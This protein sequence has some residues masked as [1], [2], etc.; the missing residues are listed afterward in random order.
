RTEPFHRGG[1]GSRGVVVDDEDARHDPLDG[2]RQL[3]GLRDEHGDERR[4]PVGA[5]VGEYRDDQPFRPEFT[6]H[7]HPSPSPP[8]ADPAVT[9]AWPAP[10]SPES[11]RS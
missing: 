2:A 10:R 1:T 8:A 3:A 4:D 11:R 5:A 7:N 9:V 6:H